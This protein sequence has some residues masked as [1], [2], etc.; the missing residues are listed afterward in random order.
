MC[1]CEFVRCPKC[2]HLF[3]AIAAIA[4]P[5]CPTMMM[6]KGLSILLPTYLLVS[7]TLHKW[8]E[9]DSNEILISLRWQTLYYVCNSSIKMRYLE[10]RKERA[11]EEHGQHGQHD[12]SETVTVV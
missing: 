5:N 3:V 4:L 7:M 1:V 9:R 10:S 6:A 2:R 8:L 12:D 11:Q